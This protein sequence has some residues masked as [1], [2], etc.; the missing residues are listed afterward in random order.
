MIGKRARRQGGRMGPAALLVAGL[1]AM[2]ATAG[3]EH[4][5]GEWPDTDFAKHSIDYAEVF[6]GGP[7]KDGIPAIDRPV[8]V[9]ADSARE[10]S[11]TEA[12][13]SVRHRRDGAGPTPCAS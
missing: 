8:F 9:P 7:P 6:S 12:V 4:W 1:L 3:P 13:I 5:R 10:L 11:P 2:E